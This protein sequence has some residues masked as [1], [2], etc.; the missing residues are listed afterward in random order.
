MKINKTI[1]ISLILIIL[2]CELKPITQFHFALTG[3]ASSGKTTMANSIKEI[4][5][6]D[7]YLIPEAA[8][9][10]KREF[11]E[12]ERNPYAN[13][14]ISEFQIRIFI[15]QIKQFKNIPKEIPIIIYDRTL[16]DSLAMSKI[17]N[18]DIPEKIISK[19][20]KY[21]SKYKFDKVFYYE[22]GEFEETEDRIEKNKK[23]SEKIGESIYSFYFTSAKQII[24]I[25]ENR[26]LEKE[27]K[28]TI[29]TKKRRKHLFRTLSERN[30][31][32]IGY[33]KTV[34]DKLYR[35][36]SDMERAL[37][38]GDKSPKKKLMQSLPERYYNK[39]PESDSEL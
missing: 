17:Y 37:S 33:T 34:R 20:K 32:R 15:K 1:K 18:I 7:C 13:E 8:T 38:E 5:G 36:V 16:L 4:F 10:V 9:I 21:I 39:K 30:I 2:F 27:I 23:D 28:T 3:A 29:K 14:N 19:V 22:I 6:D 31:Q 24:K 35:T 12:E 25:N 26:D 11:E